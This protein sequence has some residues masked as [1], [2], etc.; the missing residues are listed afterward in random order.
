MY[1]VIF[2]CKKI[3]VENSNANKK[4]FYGH[5]NGY[6]IEIYRYKKQYE[7][8][9]WNGL[10]GCICDTV[11]C[12]NI[13]HGLQEAFNN[14]SVDID[15]LVENEKDDKEITYWLDMVRKYI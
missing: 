13:T 9:C 1:S 15:D 7:V 3:P 5:W 8:S 2:R 11:I 4:E 12:K 14:I 6:T 10:G